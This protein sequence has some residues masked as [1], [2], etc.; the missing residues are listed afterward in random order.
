MFS[1]RVKEVKHV[2]LVHKMVHLFTLLGSQPDSLVQ[3]IV[4]IISVFFLLIVIV[5]ACLDGGVSEWEA[6]V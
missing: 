6:T 2:G 5:V 3:A 1:E 4:P